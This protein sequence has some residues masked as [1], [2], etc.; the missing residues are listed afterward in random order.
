MSTAS[1][2]KPAVARRMALRPA[3]QPTSSAR[4]RGSSGSQD[5]MSA[6]ACARSA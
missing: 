1:T 6:E 5:S 4:P 3:P 2:S